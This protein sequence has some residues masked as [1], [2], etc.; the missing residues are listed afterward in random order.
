MHTCV[1]KHNARMLRKVRC[2][3]SIETV[4]VK[5]MSL[6]SIELGSSELNWFVSHAMS[7]YIL[8]KDLGM[9]LE[10]NV[11]GLWPFPSHG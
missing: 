8:I 4:F 11:L 3:S 10:I 1:A 2:L 6:W 5:K 9:G 7:L